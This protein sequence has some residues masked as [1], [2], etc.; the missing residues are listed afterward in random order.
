MSA[1]KKIIHILFVGMFLFLFQM[2]SAY[3]YLRVLDPRGSWSASGEGTIEKIEMAVEPKG[4]YTRC[5]LYLTFSDRGLQFENGDSLEI[6]FYF[7]LPEKTIVQDAWL[8]IGDDIV[9]AMLIDRRKATEIYE[10]IVQRR[11]DPLI[12]YK[13]AN[14]YFNLKIFPLEAGETRKIKMS[15]LIPANWTANKVMTMLPAEFV[16]SSKN[17]PTEFS[18]YI[19]ESEQWANPVINEYQGTGQTIGQG[20][21]AGYRKLQID[22]STVASSLTLSYES[23][24]KEGLF[25]GVY[26]D[27]P[28]SYY[29]LACLPSV[30]LNGHSSKRLLFAVDYDTSGY[31]S[32]YRYWYE[33]K[34]AL[35]ED[36]RLKEL[37][38]NMK[39]YALSHLTREDDFNILLPVNGGSLVRETFV[40]ATPENIQSVFE[41]AKN[42]PYQN[43]KST[44]G[45]LVRSTREAKKSNAD[46][47][48]LSNC[49][50]HS[51][52]PDSAYAYTREIKSQVG[53]L[54]PIHI[55]DFNSGY[56]FWQNVDQGINHYPNSRM[57]AEI[58]RVTG[59]NYI[60]IYSPAAIPNGVSFLVTSMQEKIKFAE[61]ELNP[62]G[63]FSYAGIDLEGEGLSVSSGKAILKVGK[64]KGQ[65]P[66]SLSL[67]GEM[68]SLIHLEQDVQAGAICQSDSSLAKI[69]VGNYMAGL[70]KE[71][72]N[73]NTK[74]EIVQY[75]LENRILSRYTAFLALE[76]NDTVETCEDCQEEWITGTEDYGMEAN[77]SWGGEMVPTSASSEIMT[78]DQVYSSQE[79]SYNS[80][81]EEGYAEGTETCTGI[82]NNLLEGEEILSASPN[83]FNLVV[84][85][86]MDLTNIQSVEKAEI[87]NSTGNL[88]RVMDISNLSTGS[89]NTLSWNGENT[90]GE[91]VAAGIYFFKL[92]TGNG[93]FI[94]KLV[95]E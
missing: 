48:F 71:W 18:L 28:G 57:L 37:L 9:K 90:K 10:N 13:N 17:T 55:L 53:Q 87:F 40:K 59:G 51:W 5:D 56:W 60:S 85:I 46:I 7:S 32:S 22:P 43:P 26:Q 58:S 88:V 64:F 80:G 61:L 42:I 50:E 73:T 49:R 78:D 30:M 31:Y 29:Q 14:G 21:F 93:P 45:M 72:Y 76:P 27:G 24:M 4:I 79:E 82:E 67:K 63:G 89:V 35:D 25:L 36:N 69:W 54:L 41:S 95:K 83:P 15:Y 1:M 2:A 6:Q 3:S 66:F 86:S 16:A 52:Q 84:D 74:N 33:D 65:A 39:N 11:Q 62:S 34:A 19:K 8:W 70:E 92:T 91:I 75:S 81:Y 44:S 47:V 38:D 94:V 77:R 20:R 12:F 23:P 68:D